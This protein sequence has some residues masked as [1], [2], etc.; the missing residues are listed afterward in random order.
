MKRLARIGLFVTLVASLVVACAPK[1][2]PVPT[3]APPTAAPPK[4][5]P[6]EAVEGELSVIHWGSE[7]EK[8]LVAGW[9][10]QFSEDYPGVKVEQIHV[11]QNYW[12]KVAAMFAAGTPPDLMYMG[13]P[14]MVLYASE[15]TL[16]PIDDLM[17]LARR[18][19][20]RALTGD[21]CRR[22]LHLDRCP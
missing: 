6:K 9:I 21:E 4:E 5:V 12:D 18:R 14:E 13:Y 8:D 2:T 3:T 1:P 7:E 16:L 17:A 10:A 15:G 19:V 11:P 22:Y 20:T